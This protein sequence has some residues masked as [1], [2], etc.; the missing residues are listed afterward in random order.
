MGGWLLTRCINLFVI[1]I[2]LTNTMLL[3]PLVFDRGIG[4]VLTESGDARLI[5]CLLDCWLLSCDYILPAEAAL[6][7][8][9]IE[10]GTSFYSRRRS[11]IRSL[12]YADVIA[13]FLSH[14]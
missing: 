2:T 10:C 4:A 9:Q 11:S 8:A 6:G 1:T 7:L 12:R 5:Y 14:S 13:I 3:L